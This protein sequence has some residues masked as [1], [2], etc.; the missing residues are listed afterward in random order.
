MDC[1]IIGLIF[2]SGGSVLPNYDFYDIPD[3]ALLGASSSL[4]IWSSALILLLTTSLATGF[5]ISFFIGVVF[6]IYYSG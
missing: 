4:S 5:V 2:N 6:S 3:G 1:S